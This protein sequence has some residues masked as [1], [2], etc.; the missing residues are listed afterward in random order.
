MTKKKKGKQIGSG[1]TVVFSANLKTNEYCSKSISGINHREIAEDYRD[2][3]D[4]DFPDNE[5]FIFVYN[6]EAW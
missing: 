4:D 2:R 5:N 3:L 1:Q 6:A